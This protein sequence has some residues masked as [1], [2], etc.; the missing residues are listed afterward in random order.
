MKR[1]ICCCCGQDVPRRRTFEMEILK[2][3]TE[4]GPAGVLS[5]DLFNLLYDHDSEGGPLSG[6][7]TMYVMISNLNK[8]LRRNGKEISA[9]KGYKR[10]TNYTLHN[11]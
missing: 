9:P 10:S 1:A 8:R 4:A 11:L 2:I 7:T 5:D 6:K 3:V